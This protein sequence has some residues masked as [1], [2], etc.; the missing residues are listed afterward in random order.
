MTVLSQN[1]H[2]KNDPMYIL[3]ETLME[4]IKQIAETKLKEEQSD[5]N[6]I[7]AIIIGVFVIVKLIVIMATLAMKTFCL[8]MRLRS[9]NSSHI[10]NTSLLQERRGSDLLSKRGQHL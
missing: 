4:P 6:Q 10:L 9:S 2:R 1:K 8:R 3:R 7:L 5:D